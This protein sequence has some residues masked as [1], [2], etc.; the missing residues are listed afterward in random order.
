MKIKVDKEIGMSYISIID[1]NDTV[2]A[3]NIDLNIEYIW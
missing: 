2:E 3:V 1:T